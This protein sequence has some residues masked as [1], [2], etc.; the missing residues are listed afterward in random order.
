MAPLYMGNGQ[1]R[2]HIGDANWAGE[3]KGIVCC[4]VAIL[5]NDIYVA[6]SYQWSNIIRI[7]YPKMY[8]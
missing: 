3:N 1:I 5:I 4:L 2:R 7:L 8:N 6:N